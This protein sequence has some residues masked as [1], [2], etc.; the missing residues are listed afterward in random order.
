[1]SGEAIERVRRAVLKRAESV[2]R[3]ETQAA[4][5]GSWWTDAERDAARAN[6]WVP[7]V[8]L[9]DLQTLLALVDAG[10]GS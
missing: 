1:V 4:R 2:A 3:D 5:G 6:A 9:D 8:R 7:G 10:A